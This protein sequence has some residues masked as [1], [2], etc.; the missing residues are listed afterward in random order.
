MEESVISMFLDYGQLT[1]RLIYGLMLNSWI[2]SRIFDSYYC[3]RYT[4]F[5]R[6]YMT[7]PIFFF[8][9]YASA[10]INEMSFCNSLQDNKITIFFLRNRL[11]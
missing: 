5:D 8:G 4:P 6:V 1:Y 11:K 2:V 3:S 7:F 9:I 10:Y